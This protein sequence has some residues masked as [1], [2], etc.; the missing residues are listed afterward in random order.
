MS[1]SEMYCAICGTD[2]LFEAPPC[3]DGHDDECPEL[4]CTGC[5]T[6]IFMAPAVMWSF[7]RPSGRVAPLQRRAARA[8]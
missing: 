7:G 2:A 3:P 4:I 8:A 1:D 5:G 6:A